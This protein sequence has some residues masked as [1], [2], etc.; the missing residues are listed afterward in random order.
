MREKQYYKRKKS[1]EHHDQVRT[2]LGK[3]QINLVHRT[4]QF[5]NVLSMYTLVGVK[6]LPEMK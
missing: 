4:I 2:K 1:L 5:L 6:E 3:R